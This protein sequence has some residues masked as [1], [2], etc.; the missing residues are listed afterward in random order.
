MK[1]FKKSEI[2][3][4]Q[5]KSSIKLFT[6]GDYVSALTLS[7]AAHEIISNMCRARGLNWNFRFPAE[8][9]P[10]LESLSSFPEELEKFI[11]DFLHKTKNKLKHHNSFK[12]QSVQADFYFEAE[13][14]ILS[15]I[16]NYKILFNKLPE[17]NLIIAFYNKYN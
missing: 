13:M 9:A 3:I 11:Y 10:K 8:V 1:K 17:D 14:F 16:D 7:G 12:D 6:E 15:T 4:Y 5:L 2:A